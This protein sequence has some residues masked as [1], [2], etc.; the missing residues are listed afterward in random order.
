[1]LHTHLEMNGRYP[2]VG[3]IGMLSDAEISPSGMPSPYKQLLLSAWV[4]K[5]K[6]ARCCK[7]QRASVGLAVRL[8]SW[9]DA[10]QVLN[11]ALQSR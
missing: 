6:A 3:H 9:F 5:G 4:R 1:M 11:T 8:N 7:A 10:R 2:E